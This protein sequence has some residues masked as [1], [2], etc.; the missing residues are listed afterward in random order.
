LLETGRSEP[1]IELVLMLADIFG[2]TTDYLL[3][4]AIPIDDASPDTGSPD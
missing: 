4:D 2:V 3:R 1:S